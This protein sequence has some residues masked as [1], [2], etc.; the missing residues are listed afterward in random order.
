MLLDM[1]ERYKLKREIKLA[2]WEKKRLQEFCPH[3]L[4]ELED[5]REMYYGGYDVDFRT[6]Y[7]AYCPVCDK[8]LH[9][10]DKSSLTNTLLKQEARI[11]IGTFHK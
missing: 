5:K 10:N 9:F 4:V 8:T 6:V 1:I 2:E 11:S 3:Q 7:Q